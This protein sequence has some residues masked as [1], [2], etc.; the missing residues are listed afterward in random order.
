MVLIWIAYKL[1]RTLNRLNEKGEKYSIAEIITPF[2][3]S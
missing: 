1:L 2:R 3:L